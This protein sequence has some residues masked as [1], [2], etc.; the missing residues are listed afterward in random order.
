MPLPIGSRLSVYEIVAPLGAGGMGE[1][2]RAADTKL[3]RDVA[4]KVL[5]ESFASDSERLARF[6][7]EAQVLA[8]LNH[9]HIAHVY[10]LDES[11]GTQFIVMEL[12]EGETLAQRLGQRLTLDDAIAIAAQIA[13]ALEAAH[14]KGVIH[15]D[16]KPDNLFLTKAPSGEVAEIC[17]VLDFGH[18]K[19]VEPVVAANAPQVSA[20]PT[21]TTPAMMTGVGVILGTAAYMS[22]EQA[23]GRPADKRSDIWAFGCVLFEMLSGRRPFDGDDVG[24]VLAA[25]I[26][27]EPDWSAV[28]A[29][30]PAPVRTLLHRCLTKDPRQRAGDIAVARFILADWR[31]LTPELPTA[32]A[33]EVRKRP[34]WQSPAAFAAA[35]LATAI[36]VGS[37]SWMMRPVNPAPAVVRSIFTLPQGQAFSALGRREIAISPD[38]THIAYVANGRVFL[39]SLSEFDSRPIPGTDLSAPGA[40]VSDPVFSP[41]GQSVAFFVGGTIKRIAISGGA[42]VTVCATDAPFGTFGITWSEGAILVGQGPGGVVRCP[43][44]GGK[45][46]RLISVKPGE[47]AD[48]PQI[49]PGGKAVLLTIANALDGL[50]RWEKARVIMQ[51]LPSGEAT[52][53]IEGGS[54]ARYLRTG[55]LLYQLGGVVFAVPFDPA[56]ALVPRGPVS[57]LEGV[58]RSTGNVSGSSQFAISE[59]GT[60]A[61]IP[62]P[63]GG[64]IDAVELALADR[65]G[66]ATRLSVADGPY[67]QVRASRDG[68]RLAIAADDGKDAN[69]LIYDMSGSSALRRLTLAGHNRFPIWSPDGQRVAYQ[70]DRDGDPAIFAQRADNTGP[71]ERLT[72]PAPGEAHIPESWSVDGK[73]VSFSVAKDGRFSLWI[74]SIDDKKAAPLGQVQSA[75]PINSV[76][77]PDGRWIAYYTSP[78]SPAS[79]N[80]T[81]SDRGVFVQPFPANGDVYPVPKQAIDFQP[82]WMPSGKEL[83]YVPSA[84]SGEL[85][86]VGLSASPT[87]TF[88]PPVLFPARITARRLSR[89]WRA[90]DV[91][92]DGKF[93]G[94]ISQSDADDGSRG[95]TP[96]SDSQIRIAVHWFEELKQRVPIK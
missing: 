4:L 51:P 88:G 59:N 3:G 61:F 76:F 55:H 41:D 26:R 27:A 70:S 22:P 83:I 29:E 94:L 37:A 43:D 73:H 47:I 17:K 63:V 90:Y 10:G 80:G 16:L 2:Y 42:A 89:E 14:E 44:S 20:S 82:I 7:R 75:E 87:L 5:P 30:L 23:K 77:S 54:D 13:E 50:G 57:V 65:A 56:R 66:A 34:R 67:T 36:V 92:P 52:T 71:V 1:V 11:N 72:K 96:A 39:R 31:T 33:A 84:A 69:V 46:E 38:G 18:A 93:V 35:M 28:P 81:T 25:V 12:A 62:G 49:L 58:R 53:L 48:Q 40:S 45:A 78:G 64:T 86:A 8:S 95:G 19:L 79:N 15:R 24:E 60:L 68:A 91:M 32:A 21:I 74:L 85:A 6:R 9:P